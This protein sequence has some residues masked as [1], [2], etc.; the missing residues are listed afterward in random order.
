MFA[1]PFAHP[2]Y[3]M[4]KPVGALCNLRCA[5]CYYLD[6][7]SLYGTERPLMSE[8]V[9]ERFTDQYI[10]G[11]TT[12]EVLFTWHGGEALMRNRD[13]FLHALRLQQHY[14]GGHWVE[15]CI[16]TNG[17][18]LT[19]DWCRFLKDNHFLV[20]ISIDGPEH[21]HD[22]YRRTKDGKPTF[23]D[24]MRGLERL[25]RFGVEFNVLAVVNDYNV[26]YPLECYRFFKA[27]GCRYI[28]FTP[29]VERI[30]GAP[31]PWNV[32]A[33]EWGTFLISLFDEWV[34]QDIGSMFIHHFD[35]ALAAWT[36]ASPGTCIFAPTC[37]HAGVVE[38]NGDVYG[39]DHFVNPDHKLG[40]IRTSTLIEMMYSEGQLAFG[41]AKSERLGER[42]R[43]CEYLFACHGECPK[44]RIAD[45]NGSPVNYLCSGY[46]RFFRHITPAMEYMKNGLMHRQPGR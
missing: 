9:L 14:A 23:R 45:D 27:N 20:G 38:H 30:N 42:C 4:A 6:K 34:R 37:G 1:A 10:G 43:R 19:D 8:D 39:C 24:V 26:R 36:G 28:Q 3:M 15:N 46:R 2:F 12:R 7:Q 40:N 11:Q 33:G 32:P 16:Q 25:H 44:N 5:Y 35:A 22:R 29:I 31:A 18:L 17:T 13:F 41:K 21:V